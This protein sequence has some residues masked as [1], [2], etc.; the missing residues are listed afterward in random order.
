MILYHGRRGA[1]ALLWF[2]GSTAL[3]M[4]A[5][6]GAQSGWHE[7][8][9]VTAA[10][11]PL[12]FDAQ[13]RVVH[14]VTREQ[15]ARLPVR[16]VADALALVAAVDVRSRGADGLQADF[17]IRGA[18][19]GQ[20]LVLV[21]GVRINDAQS[22]HHNGDIPVTLDDIERIEVLGG[23]GSSLHG[24]DA[25]GGTIN[26][27]T[28]RDRRAPRAVV[29]GGSFGTADV[30]GTYDT[31]ALA[32]SGT[33]AR[34]DGFMYD[35]DYQNGA[36]SGSLALGSHRVRVAWLD[37]AFG[38]NGFYGA[39]P[40]KEWTSQLLATVDRSRLP[41]GRWQASWRAS[42]RAHADRFLWNV[43][44]PG[45]LENRHKSYG[46]GLSGQAEHALG[47]TTRLAIGGD[48]GGDWVRSSNLGDH[49]YGRGAAFAELR[50]QRART[51]ITPAVRAD[52][53]SDFG[54]AVSPSIA[55]GHWL[56]PVKLRGNAG[57][58]FRVPTF[59]EL[60]Y[61]DPNHI[62]SSDLRPEHAWSFEAGADV[63]ASAT[64]L[65][66]VTTFVRFE[67]DVIDWVRQ[68]PQERWQTA[69]IRD[70]TTRGVELTARRRLG[71]AGLADISYVALDSDAPDL[72]L[73]SKYVLD[74]ARHKVAMSLA[75]PVGAGL[76]AGARLGY[77]SRVDGRE[78]TLI[79][80]RVGR[81]FGD[82]TFALDLRNLLD[83]DYQEIVGVDMPGR[84]GRVE[85]AWAPR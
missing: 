12:S 59:T 7:D 81:T 72:G 11:E 55:A 16:S 83:E 78:Y 1:R 35:R 32:L 63:A 82:F 49:A 26:I 61:R 60:Y 36:L 68:T 71:E 23:A 5:P 29:G 43:T 75:A 30:A 65:V 53:Y 46:A 56:G 24:A 2:I 25:L 79:D 15:I 33:F 4:S 73:L 22:G 42:A 13:S 85:V 51:F 80:A 38:A 21:D 76:T 18:S 27:I 44:R 57:H 74:Y 20:T 9:T 14:V 28:R 6:A 52:A 47:A 58:A 10:T 8:V 66:G 54:S 64:W 62:A 69:N 70:V 3:L 67:D 37:R 34:S 39:S 31:R 40:S 17:S 77:T 50:Y 48:G 41:I 84:S 45:V 19:F